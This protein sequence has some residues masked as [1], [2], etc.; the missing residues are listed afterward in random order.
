MSFQDAVRTC[1]Q[2]YVTFSGRARRSELWF[3]VLFTFI[4]SI[5]ASIID[6]IIGTRS[7]NGTGLV[8]SLASL[9]LLLPGLAV[10]ARRLHDTSRSA[11]WLL[12]GLIPIVGAIVLIVFYVQDSHGE[13][14]YGP[15][16]KGLGGQAYAEMP[17][18]AP[19]F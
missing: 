16:P 14:Q 9:A 1:L 11:W 15:S 12:I 8:Q 2:K 17:P 13:N 18:P 19:Q 7:S 5:V 3:F 4:V 6:A 10:G